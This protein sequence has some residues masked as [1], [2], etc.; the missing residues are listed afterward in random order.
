[1][2]GRHQRGAD[3]PEANNRYMCFTARER[4]NGG[5]FFD[6]RCWPSETGGQR[7]SR[8]PAAVVPSP[9]VWRVPAR[10][11]NRCRVVAGCRARAGPGV[12][13]QHGAAPG[14]GEQ[15]VAGG[16]RADRERT[17]TT[18]QGD[19]ERSAAQAEKLERDVAATRDRRILVRWRWRVA[20][21]GAAGFVA[22]LLVPTFAS[23]W[24]TGLRD[25][26]SYPSI[27]RS[28][29]ASTRPPTLREVATCR[30]SVASVRA[31]RDWS[32]AHRYSL[33]PYMGRI[34][35]CPPSTS[36]RPP[37]RPALSGGRL[38]G[39]MHPICSVV[40]VGG[41]RRPGNAPTAAGARDR[42]APAA[43]VAP[44]GGALCHLL[45]WL[46]VGALGIQL[47]HRVSFQVDTTAAA[48]DA[49]TA[50]VGNGGLADRPTLRLVVALSRSPP[51][52]RR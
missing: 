2:Q 3:V 12:D 6:F 16:S 15:A 42:N 35:G 27:S 13:H 23:R 43:V 8:L 52:P 32:P 37:T 17:Q 9:R 41:Q 21:R 40:E 14:T 39:G 46:P 19:A 18:K 50:R 28:I 49:I 29:R 22:V 20:G 24:H 47:A 33:R 48:H 45:G 4:F 10:G 38:Q 26:V 36:P 51:E 31:A 7:R 30:F 11:C 1:M 5:Q 25:V 34:P 44:A